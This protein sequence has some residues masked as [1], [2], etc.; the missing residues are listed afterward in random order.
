MNTILSYRVVDVLNVLDV[1]DVLLLALTA[2]ASSSNSGAI[3]WLRMRWRKSI[4]PCVFCFVSVELETMEWR[5]PWVRNTL[6]I[7][8]SQSGVASLVEGRVRG[9]GR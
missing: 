3:A 4:R 5:M 2:S 6:E 8:S 1:L 9:G 7:D